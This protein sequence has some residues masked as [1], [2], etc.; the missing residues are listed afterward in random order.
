MADVLLD[1]L[2]VDKYL[3]AHLDAHANKY[4]LSFADITHDTHVQSY[5]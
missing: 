1:P 5:F 3:K 4:G 2:R